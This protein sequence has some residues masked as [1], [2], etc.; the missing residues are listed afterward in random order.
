MMLLTPLPG[1]CFLCKEY[2]SI[3][4]SPYLVFRNRAYSLRTLI[5][6]MRIGF[7]IPKALRN[8]VDARPKRIG[9]ALFSFKTEQCQRVSSVNMYYNLVPSLF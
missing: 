9:W 7:H 4:M 8:S 3:Q 6:K 2:R 1:K 5:D